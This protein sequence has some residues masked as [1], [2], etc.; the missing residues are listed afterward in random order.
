[1]S[2]AQDLKKKKSSRAPAQTTS[3]SRSK[4]SV[5]Q[6]RK[7]RH[8]E[9]DDPE[10]TMEECLKSMLESKTRKKRILTSIYP[11][12]S[13]VAE[14]N[15][16]P[17]SKKVK[18]SRVST[19]ATGIA[20]E[21]ETA[22]P[23]QPIPV[24]LPGGVT[25]E[26]V[27]GERTVGQ[28]PVVDGIAGDD[29]G[30]VNSTSSLSSTDLVRV[31]VE[32]ER[33]RHSVMREQRV[34]K[35]A[36]LS[37]E[38]LRQMI[39]RS[40]H[41][42]TTRL[43][44]NMCL[45][46]FDQALFNQ[47]SE[48][49]RC[50]DKG[51][52]APGEAEW[53]TALL[54]KNAKWWR[55]FGKLYMVMLEENDRRPEWPKE[56][57]VPV[58]EMAHHLEKAR[59]KE[60]ENKSRQLEYS[61]AR[62][63]GEFH[64]G[65]ENFVSQFD[66]PVWTDE[67]EN[68]VDISDEGEVES[69]E[70]VRRGHEG[71]GTSKLH[72]PHDRIG[73]PFVPI[74]RPQEE[75]DPDLEDEE[76]QDDEEEE[77][78]V[79]EEDED[80]E[81]TFPISPPNI[82]GPI[83]HSVNVS[84]TTSHA[85][86]NFSAGRRTDSFSPSTPV[87]TPARART[88]SETLRQGETSADLRQREAEAWTRQ[89]PSH[90]AGASRTT[91][92]GSSQFVPFQ[93]R[94]RYIPQ[95]RD[96]PRSYFDERLHA[97]REQPRGEFRER[98]R[99]RS[100]SREREHN[101]DEFRERSRYVPQEREY[102]RG[103]VER[104]EFFSPYT[105]STP[106]VNGGHYH[107][108]RYPSP[109]PSRHF[110]SYPPTT[111]VV[112]SQ[113]VGKATLEKVLSYESVARLKLIW[114][115]NLAQ[116]I[117]FRRESYFSKPLLRQ[118]AFELYEKR[119]IPI[120]DAR[121]FAE[122]RDVDFFR[123][124]EA[125]V[126][127]DG[128]AGANMDPYLSF[129]HQ[130]AEID[131]K[132]DASKPR[133][134][135]NA[136]G[137]IDKLTRTHPAQ[138]GGQ[139][140]EQKQIVILVKEHLKRQPLSERNKTFCDNMLNAAGRMP[141]PPNGVTWPMLRIFLTSHLN[142][143]FQSVR[144]VADN[145]G[146]SLTDTKNSSKT[147]SS[148]S[149]SSSATS[150]GGERQ[151]NS[152]GVASSK[153]RDI[154]ERMS[155]TLCG[156]NQ[157]KGEQCHYRDH[158]ERNQSS[159]IWKESVQGKKAKAAGYDVLPAT[160]LLDG[161]IWQGAHS[162]L[163]NKVSAISEIKTTKPAKAK[164]PY[165]PNKE[166]AKKPISSK[167]TIIATCKCLTATCTNA[168]T[169]PI[170]CVIMCGTLEIS[171]L[172][173]IDTGALQSNFISQS[174][175]TKLGG[176]VT[177][178]P[179]QGGMVCSA[180]SK[181][182]TR[183]LEEID[184]TVMFPALT[185][186]KSNLIPLTCI[187]I[188]SDFD[189][190]IG[191]PTILKYN[192]LSKI[193][194]SEPIASLI[195]EDSDADLTQYQPI[196]DDTSMLSM[197]ETKELREL[198]PG[199][200]KEDP[201]FQMYDEDIILSYEV[202]VN[203]IDPLVHTIEGSIQLQFN[204]RKLLRKYSD[205]FSTHVRATPAK[206]EPMKIGADLAGWQKRV[207]QQRP[208]GHSAAKQ[209]EIRTQIVKMLLL[210]VIR[211]CRE[212]YF[213]QVHM[214]P[215]GNNQWRFCIDFRSLN[216]VSPSKGWSIP[217]ID[218]LLQRI[219][220]KKAKYFCTL[221]LTAGYHQI[222]VSTESI[223]FTAFTTAG[224]TY[225]WLR[226]PMGLKGATAH[227][228]SLMVAVVLAGLNY[229]IC[230]AYLDDIV[231]FG[232]T[233][234]ELISNMEQVFEKLRLYNIALNPSKC[235][236]GMQE[237][238]F[239]GHTINQHGLSFS[240]EKLRAVAEFTR[241][242]TQTELRSFLGLANY[243]R[244]HIKGHSTIVKSIFGLLVGRDKR[245]K[246]DWT[247][248]AS[249]AFLKLKVAI[250]ACPTLF[251][252]DTVSPIFLHTDA[253]NYGIGAY[254]FQLRD[255]VEHPVRFMSKAFT[256][257]QTNWSTIEKECFAIVAT[258]REWKHLLLD[259]HF[260][261]RTDH[262][263]LTYIGKEAP[264][265]KV[266]RWMLEIQ[267]FDCSV[268]HIEGPLNIAADTLSRCQPSQ[269]LPR[270]LVAGLTDVPYTTISEVHNAEVGHHGLKRTLTL[271]DKQGKDWATRT[272]DVTY[273]IAHC[274]WCQKSDFRHPKV[275]TDPFFTEVSRP[276]ERLCV[277]TMGPFVATPEEYKYILAVVD[278]FTRHVK[279]YRLKT[280]TGLEM[281]RNLL[282]HTCTWG[283]PTHIQ[284][285]NGS[286]FKNEHMEALKQLINTTHVTTL[287][288]SSEDNGLVERVNKEVMRHL[289]CLVSQSVQLESWGDCLPLVER[290]LNSAPHASLNGI[291][292][293]Q[294]HFG[295]TFDLDK[296]FITPLSAEGPAVAPTEW[297][298]GLLQAQIDLVE[299]SKAFMDSEHEK[300]SNSKGT[301]RTVHAI[302]TWVYIDYPKSHFGSGA[303]SKLMPNR[304]GPHQVTE[305]NGDEYTIFNATLGKS[306][307]V[308]VTR[309]HPAKFDPLRSSPE[310]FNVLDKQMYIIESILKHKGS[311][312]PTSRRS[313]KFLVH[314]KGFLETEATWEPWKN[315]CKTVQ[316]HDYLRSKGLEKHIPSAFT[317]AT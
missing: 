272:A 245:R 11:I 211:P 256:P 2:G 187:I 79:R 124:V 1:M 215:K 48:L 102:E 133:A 240:P 96:P 274:L 94:E 242:V 235:K 261:L 12:P 243:F 224:G 184:T 253:S 277:D 95:E 201:S 296:G 149:S 121:F 165:L 75:S 3:R 259:T 46:H 199:A 213:S 249:A 37:I 72:F 290:I 260:T 223:P 10:P 232:S 113:D 209:E 238:E 161:S 155:C 220:S 138:F 188:Q 40:D 286:Q 299:Q 142:N 118:I 141:K 80:S 280:T 186:Q 145:N 99:T 131:C 146:A 202:E 144:H 254:L 105:T 41:P 250:A 117:T 125:L 177:K 167:S 291:S 97:A 206:L 176:E 228:Q 212:P 92:Y 21:Q 198:L 292:P 285:D 108:Q 304:M 229:H 6:K 218:H 110:D 140:L 226:L 62:E 300:H 289:R 216:S 119:V 22:Q 241:P 98:G 19:T 268:E 86:S 315:V 66:G 263:N 127:L 44:K 56:L 297:Y 39:L 210:N 168:N 34:A 267:E 276:A 5:P 200:D 282:E 148:S 143:H 17:K 316:L 174:V 36:G 193:F 182:C 311:F 135:Q 295:N 205:L 255:G 77:E 236:F 33:N 208:R 20:V 287:A 29:E 173:L 180:F 231:I 51:D 128:V 122:W 308:H 139:E 15:H 129:K 278:A 87:A 58:M 74:R 100:D 8:F 107:S 25:T 314:W 13:P 59:R 203:P 195:S 284:T 163:H 28:S 18:R 171:C 114:E 14:E 302:G 307:R 281:A 197:L 196:I 303:P 207:N 194:H 81:A 266:M 275:Y 214:T 166:K 246:V 158:P 4:T 305:R 60:L 93:E 24:T 101:R 70:K 126:R 43:L 30:D 162:S 227:F 265:A 179:Y 27:T 52:W 69:W 248:E 9:E 65:R 104:A 157:P 130:L 257:V 252:M 55:A 90:F 181:V 42:P 76:E 306:D 279:L 137:A 103:A 192:L 120:C 310:E 273:F 47:Y 88:A 178:K 71:G 154:K 156:R 82:P 219:G 313:N 57:L 244:G 68:D 183:P 67:Y 237:V 151:E 32:K 91:N 26:A 170:P 45:H 172:A 239:V 49:L 233:E 78:E 112:L 312:V 164:S 293:I 53:L 270:N 132:F 251:F 222:A 31:V 204:I 152:K 269:E 258:L 89:T 298:A 115:S 309:L 136:F 61:L 234:E 64:K 35:K 159:A 317:T 150:E 160:K 185:N 169:N 83:P 54:L 190:I 23:S 63:R 116:Q 85:N 271:L 50:E 175:A 294:L 230:E 288:Y 73:R 217:Q 111:T 264:S 134:L 147:S 225:E 283:V 189:L 16:V 84:A 123:E 153:K 262:K 7:K 247:E 221:D 191:L 38:E 109:N 106:S 301:L